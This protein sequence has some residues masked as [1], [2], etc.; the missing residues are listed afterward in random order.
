MSLVQMARVSV[1]LCGLLVVS[2]LVVADR[3]RLVDDR[4]EAR[5]LVGGVVDGAHGTVRLDQRVLTLD[6]IT[7]A[8][9]VLRLH[10]P[11]VEVVDSVLEGVLGRGLL[12]KRS[13]TGRFSE[14][15]PDRDRDDRRQGRALLT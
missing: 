14:S 15:G 3:S 1:D 5:V 13:E 4:V 10:V 7:V 2:A 9:L 11:G 12:A 8:R 6:D